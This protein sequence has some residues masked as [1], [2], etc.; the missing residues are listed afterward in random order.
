MAGVK[1]INKTDTILIAAGINHYSQLGLGDFQGCVNDAVAIKNKIKPNIS[2]VLTNDSATL[3]NILKAFETAASLAGTEDYFIFYFAGISA[4]NNEN[5]TFLLPYMSQWPDTSFASWGFL[6]KT[7]NAGACISLLQL[8]KWMENIP[9]NKQLIITEAGDGNSFGHSLINRLFENNPILAADNN[10]ERVII[11]TNGLGWEGR[12]C[13]DSKEKIPGGILTYFLTQSSGILNVFE[14]PDLFEFELLSTEI[15]C[16]PF[17]GGMIYSRIYREKEFND[18]LVKREKSVQGRGITLENKEAELPVP[19]S[20][21]AV[22]YALLI[23]T[24]KYTG[25]PAWRDLGNPVN[26][27]ESVGDLLENK[28]GCKTIRLYNKPQDSLLREIVLLKKK[29]RE[30]DNLLVFI[31]GHGY[32]DQ[33]FSDG[34]IVAC[35]SRTPEDDMS[36]NTYIQMASLCRLLDNSVCKNIFV[37]FDVCFGAYFDFN[38]RD[39]SISDYSGEV[40][41]IGIDELIKRKSEYYSRIYMASGKGEVPDYW[42]GSATHSPFAAKLIDFLTAEK[43]F[44]TPGKIFSYLEMNITEPVLKEFGRHEARGD[45]ILKAR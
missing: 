7:A 8:S 42:K 28:Y 26:D 6:N 17:R 35:D 15:R 11:T 18:L 36:H 31:A 24:D 2:F 10:R 14:K 38:A 1:P 20:L 27:A 12:P 39:L 30:K 34:F 29:L 9:S 32:Y 40:S 3:Q 37:I 44:I 5:E 22:S 23:A 43:S 19:D 4:Q 25:K 21:K 45:F 33:D 41:D 13:I 16:N